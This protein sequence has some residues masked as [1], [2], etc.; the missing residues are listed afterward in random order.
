VCKDC[1]GALK[2]WMVHLDVRF[3]KEDRLST[4]FWH[5]L[6]SRVER[7]AVRHRA[8]LAVKRGGLNN[9]QPIHTI[10][11]RLLPRKTLAAST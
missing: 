9:A 10:E 7:R 5:L 8:S 1:A 3:N 6:G 4:I 2:T 11:A